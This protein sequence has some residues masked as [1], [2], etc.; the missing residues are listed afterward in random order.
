[1]LDRDEGLRNINENLH[2]AIGL[3]LIEI[4]ILQIL[5]SC[6]RVE[7]SFRSEQYEQEK[8]NNQQGRLVPQEETVEPCEQGRDI[9]M[10]PLE[11]ILRGDIRH[12]GWGT[13]ANIPYLIRC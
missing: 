9:V 1:M 3:N 12:F 10:E 5:G 4:G 6:Q 7:W 13:A 2:D 8:D 11:V